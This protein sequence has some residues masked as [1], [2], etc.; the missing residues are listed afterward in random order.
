MLTGR[1]FRNLSGRVKPPI[2]KKIPNPHKT[3]PLFCSQLGGFSIA[4]LI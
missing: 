4:S 3:G 2:R 1:L